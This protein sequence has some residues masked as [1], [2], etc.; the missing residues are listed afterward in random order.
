MVVPLLVL[1]MMVPM[2]ASSPGAN[3]VWSHNTVL[4]NSD[5]KVNIKANI[6]IS[7]EEA[8]DLY[9]KGSRRKNNSYSR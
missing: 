9:M 4:V 1:V 3:V 8:F 7:P 2:F 6:K 5:E